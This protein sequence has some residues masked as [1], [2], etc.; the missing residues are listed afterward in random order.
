[1][2]RRGVLLYYPRP[3]AT[4]AALPESKGIGHSEAKVIALVPSTRLESKGTLH[5]G[6]FSRPV[7]KVTV[8]TKSSSAGG[9]VYRY[10]Y[11]RARFVLDRLATRAE[12]NRDH[13]QE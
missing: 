4:D 13:D 9:G 7:P 2:C 1:M 5:S 11:L 12:M 3:T 8:T 10:N 6:D